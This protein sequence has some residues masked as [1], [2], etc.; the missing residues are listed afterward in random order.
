ME[1]IS[2][3]LFFGEKK[4]QPEDVN[5]VHLCRLIDVTSLVYSPGVKLG[6]Y[7]DQFYICINSEIILNIIL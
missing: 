3:L 7:K 5:K 4:I 1:K 2:R 6:F